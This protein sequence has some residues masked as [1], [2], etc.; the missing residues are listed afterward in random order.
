MDTDRCTECGRKPSQPNTPAEAD[1][2]TNLWR[3]R[4]GWTEKGREAARI[5]YCNT[6]GVRIDKR[7]KFYDRP[8]SGQP[9]TKTAAPRRACGIFS[10][11]QSEQ[12]ANTDSKHGL[13]MSAFEA[14]YYRSEDQYHNRTMKQFTEAAQRIDDNLARAME[15]ITK[16]EGQ[17]ATVNALGPMW[18]TRS[19]YARPMGVLS[20][21]HLRAILDGTWGSGAQRTYAANEVARREEDAQWREK[22]AKPVIVRPCQS[23][24]QARTE[25]N[26]ELSSALEN[27]IA[28]A[29]RGVMLPSHIRVAM[30]WLIRAQ[31]KVDA[32]YGGA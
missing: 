16:L 23:V 25:A 1:A 19:G 30:D 4:Y 20:T 22:Q 7:R 27:L 12:T 24:V 6:C 8:D 9:E 11:P 29:P 3:M 2:K 15:R 17:L 28:K 14:T 5:L 31:E 10:R 13:T 32:L 26:A 18:K 21:N